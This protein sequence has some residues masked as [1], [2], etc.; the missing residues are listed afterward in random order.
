MC[1]LDAVKHK[2]LIKFDSSQSQALKKTS[3]KTLRKIALIHIYTN[4][5]AVWRRK[6][7][8]RV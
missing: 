5:V 2:L 6:V 3:D 8:L 7:R 1:L 4:K